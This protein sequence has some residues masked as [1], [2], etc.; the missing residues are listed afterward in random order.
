MFHKLDSLL[1]VLKT[2][3]IIICFKNLVHY[4]MFWKLDSLLYVFKSRFILICFAFFLLDSGPGQLTSFM[5]ILSY[6][7]GF[8]KPWSPNLLAI[9]LFNFFHYFI[10][11]YSGKESCNR[12]N[13]SF[14]MLREDDDKLIFFERFFK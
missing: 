2:R 6:E 7:A 9:N 3:F 1:Y 13:S 14:K 10:L 12:S 8:Y 5:S 11:E 4:Y